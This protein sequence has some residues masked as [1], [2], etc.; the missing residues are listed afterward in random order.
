LIKI[1]D[2]RNGRKRKKDYQVLVDRTTI[3][4]HPEVRYGEDMDTRKEFHYSYKKWILKQIF[5]KYN[6]KIIYK[7]LQLQKINKKHNKLELYCWCGEEKYCH[8]EIIRDILLD[9]EMMSDIEILSRII[10]GGKNE[11]N[12]KK[13]R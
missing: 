8:S 7:L 1:Y 5:H 6:K 13:R 4:G 12:K 11:N 3:L 2:I 10:A 9:E